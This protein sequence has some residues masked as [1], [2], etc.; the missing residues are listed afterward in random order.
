MH[1][2]HC[3]STGVALL[4]AVL[5][6]LSSLVVPS[7]TV[8]QLK[9]NP[10]PMKAPGNREAGAGRSDTCASTTGSSGLTAILPISNLGL[11][12]K[13]NPSFFAYVPPNNAEKA[14]F[15]LV[16]ESTGKGIYTGELQLPT[17][18][19]SKAM[20]K[21]PAAILSL[22]LPSQDST[23]ALEPDKNYLWAVMVI[24]N[25]KN[26]AEDI[27]TTGVIQRIGNRY[28]E[29]LDP[30][31]RTK[32]S[33]VEEASPEEQAAIYGSAGIWNDMLAQTISLTDGKKEFQNLLDDQGLKSIAETPIVQTPLAPINP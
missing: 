9:F 31:I 26:R 24:C 14:E 13:A 2:S 18:T 28:L 4:G 32:L 23:S 10:P 19:D 21:H 22:S 27:V 6:S 16:E 8:A 25:P 1:P 20:Y 30:T 17:S 3:Q 11:T 15:R 29:T 7:A 33:R 5:L 12:T